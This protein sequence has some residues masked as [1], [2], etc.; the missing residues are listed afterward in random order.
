MNGIVVQSVPG[1]ASTRLCRDCRHRDHDSRVLE[2]MIPGLASFGSAFSASV[3][4]SRL[5]RLRDQLVSPRDSC[6][7]FSQK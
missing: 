1:N 4:G 7:Q 3:G 2:A 5:C 6:A